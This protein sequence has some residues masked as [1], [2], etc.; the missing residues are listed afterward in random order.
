MAKVAN[1]RPQS[2]AGWFDCSYSPLREGFYAV[3]IKQLAAC[4]VVSTGRDRGFPDARQV[5]GA[6][7][8]CSGCSG[9]QQVP[10][11]YS[12]AASP[13]YFSASPQ[14][15]PTTW[16]MPICATHPPFGRRPRK[17]S[18]HAR[19]IMYSPT[20]LHARCWKNPSRR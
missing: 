11:K 14:A 4:G 12:A 6:C 9:V 1:V 20:L 7:G 13:G 10:S 17:S 19:I 5:Q 18:E 8:W 16:P 15:G 3:D 2:L